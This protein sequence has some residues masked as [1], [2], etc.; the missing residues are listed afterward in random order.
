VSDRNLELLRSLPR[1]HVSAKVAGYNKR[2]QLT[3]DE[4]RSNSIPYKAQ[5]K[6]LP[7]LSI[8]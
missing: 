6:R 7:Q 4:M 1:K 2:L 8:K 5:R 3:Y